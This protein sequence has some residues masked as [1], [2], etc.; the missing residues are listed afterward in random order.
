MYI[1]L[2]QAYTD[3][4]EYINCLQP[5]S[6]TSLPIPICE[7]ASSPLGPINPLAL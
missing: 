1:C 4:N 6:C 2:K 3:F 7:A 5:R